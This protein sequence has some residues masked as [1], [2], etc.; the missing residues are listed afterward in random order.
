M[1]SKVF[2]F[3]LLH[4]IKK[5]QEE[6]EYEPGFKNRAISCLRQSDFYDSTDITI[7]KINLELQSLF[8]YYNANLAIVQKK[9]K[10]L[11]NERELLLNRKLE[12]FYKF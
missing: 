6:D 7:Q 12:D 5:N 3:G 1:T 11:L 2:Q 10:T 9:I 8:M 4:N